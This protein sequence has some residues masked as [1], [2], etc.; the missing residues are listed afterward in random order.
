MIDK[1]SSFLFEIQKLCAIERK[2]RS[3]DLGYNEREELRNEE[4]KSILKD[5]KAWLLENAT[6]S[7]SKILPKSKIGKAVNLQQKLD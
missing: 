1:A 2:A 4:S 3:Q 6:E 7:N 5:L